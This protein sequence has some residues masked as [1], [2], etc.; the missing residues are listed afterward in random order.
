MLSN[1]NFLLKAKKEKVD[2]EK[3]KLAKNLEKKKQY[4]NKLE[5]LK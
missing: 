2:L 3:E 5:S 4:L 1:E